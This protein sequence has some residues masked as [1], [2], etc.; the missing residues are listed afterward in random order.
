MT[1]IVDATRNVPDSAARIERR[2]AK[3]VSLGIELHAAAKSGEVARIAL[4][5]RHG[6]NVRA[7]MPNGW[8]PLHA[9]ARRGRSASVEALIEAGADP[10]LPDENGMT[11]LHLAAII[12]DRASITALV[13]AGADTAAKDAEGLSPFDVLPPSAPD[14]VRTL[15]RPGADP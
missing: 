12:G 8:T 5:I 9:A 15:C 4:L 10:N 2:E 7:R 1:A 14:A 13:Q 6:A 3:A 11:P